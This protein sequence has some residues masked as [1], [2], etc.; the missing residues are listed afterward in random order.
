MKT[1]LTLVLFLILAQLTLFGQDGVLDPTFGDG[2]IATTDFFLK[3]DLAYEMAQQDDDKLLVV[4]TSYALDFS[5]N[6]AL[7]ARFHTDGSL[8]VTF[9][10]DGSVLAEDTSGHNSFLRVSLQSSGNIIVHGARGSPSGSQGYLT[11]FLPSGVVDINFGTNGVVDISSVAKLKVLDDDKLL[12]LHGVINGGSTIGFSRYLENGSI[13]NSY[14]VNG[15]ATSSLPSGSFSSSSMVQMASGEIIVQGRRKKPTT[16][17]FIVMKFTADGYLNQNFGTNGET[18]IAFDDLSVQDYNAS[19]GTITSEGKIIV[20]GSYGHCDYEIQPFL[21]RLLSNGAFDLSFGDNGL[22]MLEQSSFRPKDVIVQGNQRILVSGRWTDCI[23]SGSLTTHR[24]F[25]NGNVDT[26][27][28]NN[29]R[30]YLEMNGD[31]AM[32]QNDGNIVISGSSWWHSGE[33]DIVMARYTNNPLGIDENV[34]QTANIYPNPSTGTFVLEL[35]NLIKPIIY[36][37]LDVSGKIIKT[38]MLF[39][40]ATTLDISEVQSGLYFLK[41]ESSTLQLIKE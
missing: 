13:D 32:L 28:G 17:E 40:V 26:S 7:L 20:A 30:T 29:G 24:Y 9:G 38:G 8:D 33:E 19:A 10:I 39:D 23:D 27:Y 3:R 18:V 34:H 36:S 16:S 25:T 2:G 5:E 21:L 4:G 41:V 31:K 37:V 15:T 22:R 11:R 1:K 6:S 35:P 12:I 14:G